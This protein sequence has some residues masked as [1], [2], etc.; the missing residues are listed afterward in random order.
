MNCRICSGTTKSSYLLHS[1]RSDLTVQTFY[2]RRC[3]FFFSSGAPVNYTTYHSNF[4]LVGYYLRAEPWIRARY[5]KIFSFTESLVAPG[6]FLDIGAGI[7]YS[8]EVAKKRGWTAVGLEPNAELSHHAKGRGLDVNH[9]YF[10]DETTGEFDFILIDNVLEHI[11]EPADFL[12]RAGRLMAHSGV[13]LVAVP[14]LDWLRKGLGAITYV[15][16]S[17]SLPQLNVFQEV[18]EHVNMFSRTAMNRLLKNTDLQLLDIRFHHSR[19]YNNPL[20]RSL[21]LDDGNYFIVRA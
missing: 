8:L 9:A 16:N 15:R 12:R 19:A 21:R 14:P 11:L 20:F 5:H 18:D 13:L 7:G 2:C 4:D 10:S 17:I 1:N 6:R 3:D